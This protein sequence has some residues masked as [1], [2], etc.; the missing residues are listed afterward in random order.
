MPSDQNR[1]KFLATAAGAA[2]FTIVPR[3]VLGGPSYIPPSDKITLAHIGV[4]TE[5]LREMLSLL[6]IPEIQIVAVCDPNKDAV[7]YR[8]W[9]ANGLRDDIRRALKKPDWKAGT[10]QH[11]PRR[12]RRRQRHHRYLL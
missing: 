4:G 5:G 9:S 8:D 1:R 11:D 6:P 12:A 3:H 2:A 7:G 10:R